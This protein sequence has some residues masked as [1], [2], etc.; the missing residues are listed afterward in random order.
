MTRQTVVSIDGSAFRINGRPTYPGRSWNGHAVEGLLMNARFVQATFND[1]NPQTQA[2]WNYPDGAAF[3]PDRN[4]REFLAMLP[5]WRKAG[6]LSFTVNLQGGSPQGYS[7]VQPW[8]NSAFEPDGSLRGDDLRRMEQ[9]LDAADALGMAPILGY[10]YFG[11]EPKMD[12]EAAILR[13]TDNATDWLL[14]RGYTN[15]MVEIA[16]ECNI[17]YRQ[18][19]IGPARAHELIERVQKR[20][21]GKLPTPAGRLLVSISYTGQTIPTENIVAVSD[22]VLL[23]GNGVHEPHRIREMVR[24]TRALAT[25]RGQPIVFNEDDHFDFER[26]ENNMAVAVASG[27]SWGLFDY[28]F[29]GEGFTEGYQSPP[30]DWTTSSERK[31]GFF[32]LLAD[33]TGGDATEALA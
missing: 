14:D 30:I 11:Q 15:V 33:I 28:R 9:V 5:R 6:L 23:H 18:P 12:G 16:N 10:F 19:I 8:I 26:P 2:L 20:S 27:A 29:D 4:T 17:H 25:Y 13:A 3:D 24:K 31:R 22:F 32:K 1:R 7:T 21:A